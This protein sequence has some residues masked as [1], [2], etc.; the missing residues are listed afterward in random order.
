MRAA[1]GPPAR[2]LALAGAGVAALVA[3]RGF[4]TP[5]L[6]VLGAGML[7]LPVLVTAAVWAAASG[8]RVRRRLD[9]ARCRAGEEV[10][11]TT[12]LAGWAVRAGLDRVLD[13]AVDP[14]IGEAAGGEGAAA[15]GAGRW[16]F[17][18]VRGDHALPP[19]RATIRDPFG[20]ARASREGAS[21]EG[22][23]VVPA[24]PAIGGAPAGARAPGRGARRRRAETGFGE[25]D[26]VRDY[27]PGDPLSRV[28]WAQTAKRGRLQTKELR[29]T[30]TAGRATLVLLDGAGP[31][32]E[33]LE[34]AVTAAAAIAR[35]LMAR[36]DPVAVVHT[37]R[38][39][40][41]LVA[42]LATWPLVEIALAR[43]SGGGARPAAL[44]LSAEAGGAD[45][46]D[47]AVLV[48][49]AGDPALPAAVR[50]VRAHG[51]GVAVVLTG[52][53][54]AGAG[55]LEAAGA[56]VVVVPGPDRVA[57]ALGAGPQPARAAAG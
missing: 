8:M 23:L 19:P 35:H 2:A 12:S 52:P 28:H 32:G 50:R 38:V 51:V 56:E 17:P 31:D 16:A 37:G 5:A 45:A 54:A 21:G 40:A 34:T 55:D 7:A 36:G 11:V 18:A 20:L 48:T 22:L 46:P 4:G 42:G 44:A 43:F 9:P 3:S 14:G 49:S 1:A 10:T 27:Q 39:P 24:A 6:A 30:E 15:R 57:S 25:L 29:A 41:R 47:T 33:A 13:V 26:R 53:A